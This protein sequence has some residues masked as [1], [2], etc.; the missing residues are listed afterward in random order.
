MEISS[1][2][3]KRALSISLVLNSAFL[4]V[5]LGIGFW[6][7][8]LALLSDAAHMVSDV[9]ALGLALGAN[10]L[11]NRLT[12][13]ERTFG[14][15]RAEALGAFVNALALVVT[16]GFIFREAIERLVH[17]APGIDGLPVL[18]AGALGLLINLGSAWILARA[19][20][21]NLNVRGAL[22]HMLSDALGSVG[23]IVA[24]ILLMMGMPAADAGISLL[25]GLLVL[26]GTWGLLRDSAA[27]LLEFSPKGLS[28]KQVQ[29]ELSSLGDV[30]SVHD[31]HIWSLDGKTP[32]LSAHLVRHTG[33]PAGNLLQEAEALLARR[34]G[35]T[36]S[37]LQIES[38]NAEPCRARECCNLLPQSQLPE[39]TA[40]ASLREGA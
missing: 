26:V 23:A 25:I 6:T 33:L 39:A 2:S 38:P 28:V 8:S 21:D 34:F 37:T 1:A 10:S 27:V 32:I 19:D 20:Q 24:A 15:V 29:K 16:C 35:V 7:G 18:I 36:H 13:S 22:L 40:N 17:G 3:V 11:A 4:V 14:L 30:A 9:A 12:H 31:L 5:E